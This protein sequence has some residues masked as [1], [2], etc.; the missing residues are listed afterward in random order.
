MRS[1][2][3]PLAARRQRQLKQAQ[4]HW[5]EENEFSL[6]LMQ[7]FAAGSHTVP[8]MVFTF[9]QTGLPGPVVGPVNGPW[10]K[11]QTRRTLTA[12]S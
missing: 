11:S 4:G 7:H 8:W 10:K 12:R 1:S 3:L 6:I 9:T 2:S 5:V